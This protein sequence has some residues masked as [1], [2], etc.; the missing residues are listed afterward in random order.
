MEEAAQAAILQAAE[1]EIGAAVR[2]V[3]VEQALA[4]ALV[5]EQHEVLAEH[6][7]RLGGRSRASS[8]ASATGCQ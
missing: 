4:A 6:A 5:A 8:S 1:G 7:H 2:A 3:A